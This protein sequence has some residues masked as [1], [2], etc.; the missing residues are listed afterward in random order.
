MSMRCCFR[1]DDGN[2]CQAWAMRN[3]RFCNNHQPRGLNDPGTYSRD[4][5]PMLHPIARLATPSDLFDLIRETLNA[6]RMGRI[7]PSQAFAVSSV[8][9][10]WLEV[11]DKLE[12][13]ERLHALQEQIL[14]SLVDAESAAHA[15]REA[16]LT[17]ATQE[18]PDPELVPPQQGLAEAA[19][20]APVDTRP[21]DVVLEE[22]VG[23]ALRSQAAAHKSP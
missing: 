19:P 16:K 12:W 18:Q 6:I 2:Y 13:E 5:W 20:P 4:G 3:S 23:E 15:E 17:A 21:F 10:R 8:A 22:L 14:P 1:Y 9:G 7:T 11:Y